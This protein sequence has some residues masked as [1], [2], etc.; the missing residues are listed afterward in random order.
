MAELQ[1]TYGNFKVYGEVQGLKRNYAFNDQPTKSG[2]ERNH[3]KFDV[4]TSEDNIV[5]VE[6]Q[7]MDFGNVRITPR[8]REDKQYKDLDRTDKVYDEIPEDWQVMMGV[9]VGLEQDDKGE[10][11][12]VEKDSYDAAR[13]IYENLND[14]DVVFISGRL[15]VNAFT[16]RNDEQ[17]VQMQH[18]I[19]RLYKSN[20]EFDPSAEDFQEL[21]SFDQNLIINDVELD[22]KE[23]KAWVHSYLVYNRDKDFVPFTFWVDGNKNVKLG[24]NLSKLKFGTQ[25]K[26]EGN[27]LSTVTYEEQ[28]EETDEWGSSPSGYEKRSIKNVE[29]SYEITKGLPETMEEEKYTDEDF[30]KDDGNNDKDNP[31]KNDVE[32]GNSEWGS[33]P[34]SDGGDSSDPFA[35]AEW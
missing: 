23:K 26:F 22:K 34:N 13:Y 33:E 14:G 35:D 11:I 5:T 20:K 6:L 24:K 3:V 21:S 4:K 29:K 2:Y 17:V 1:R 9:N 32:E 16:N 30:V 27:L 19:S 8:D 15:E 7:G 12:K 31:F 10:N 25:M 28:E 18:V